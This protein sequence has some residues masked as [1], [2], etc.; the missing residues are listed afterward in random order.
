VAR[1]NEAGVP[2]GP[3][4]SVDQVFGD[5]QV[6]HLGIAQGLEKPG[7]AGQKGGRIDYVGQ[8]VVLSRTPSRVV[9]HPPALGEHTDEI[10]GELGYDKAS[11]DKL[12]AEKVI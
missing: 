5:E 11:L 12:R 2:C 9:K 7:P 10:L 6:K 4:Y 3:I 8:P 1:F